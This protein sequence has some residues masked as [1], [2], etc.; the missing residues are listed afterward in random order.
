MTEFD[1][2]GDA[3]TLE[4]FFSEYPETAVAFSGGADSAFLLYCAKKYAKKVIAYYVKSAFQPEFELADAKRFC[5]EFDVDLKI[6]NIDILSDE[7]VCKN[8]ENRCYNCKKQIMTAIKNQA[9]KDG[10]GIAIDGTNASDNADD[11]PGFKALNELEILSPLRLCGIT[12]NEVRYFSKTAGLFTY[13]KSAYA[14]LATRIQLGENI[15]KDK[16]EKTEKAE[17]LL[18]SMGFRDFR[19]RMSGSAAK[20]EICANQLDLL[21]EKRKSILKELK[22]EYSSVFLNLEFRNE[23]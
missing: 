1:V 11:R 9:E 13:N 12:K 22:K 7:A 18:F 6:I 14:C 8:D 16:L 15:T 17:N 4:Q 3:L 5:K 19:V 21:T 2:G 23:Q 10:F 20:L